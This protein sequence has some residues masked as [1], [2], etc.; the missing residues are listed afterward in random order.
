MAACGVRGQ[1]NLVVVAVLLAGCTEGPGGS[2]TGSATATPVPTTAHEVL[3]GQPSLKILG[4]ATVQWN[5]QNATEEQIQVVST[6][7]YIGLTVSSG[8][9]DRDAGIIFAAAIPANATDTLGPCA[10]QSPGV[11]AFFRPRDTGNNNFGNLTGDYDAGWYHFV[12]AADSPGGFD[13]EFE[14]GGP[15]P[16]KLPAED[17][18]VQA[19]A[20]SVKTGARQLSADVASGGLPW[21]SWSHHAIGGNQLSVDGGRTHKL[22]YNDNCAEVT[23][24]STGATIQNNARNLATAAA[25]VSTGVAAQ[26]TYT[27]SQAA[28]APTDTTL[29]TLWVTVEPVTIPENATASPGPS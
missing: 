10:A 26:G 21:F 9:H 23:R 1:T 11:R 3:L 25:G 28:T 22:A 5:L 7:V 20:Y 12:V 4:P 18:Y 29:S 24:T 2:P 19:L 27:P 13:L 6:L 8:D 17:P 15:N 14:G 16:R